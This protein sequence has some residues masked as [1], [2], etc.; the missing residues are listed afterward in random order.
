MV[1]ARLIVL[2]LTLLMPAQLRAESFVDIIARV[3]PGIVGI[4]SHNPLARPPNDL[5][6]TGL[7]VGDGNHVVTAYHVVEGVAKL[8]RGQLSVFIGQGERAAVRGATLVAHDEL[9]DMA[10][11]KVDGKPL[12]PLKLHRGDRVPDGTGIAFTG[13]PVGAVYGL[14]PATHR[15]IVAASTPMARPLVTAGE[16]TPEMIHRLQE[17]IVVYQLDATA[18]PGNSGGPVYSDT[19][20]EVIAILNSTFVK[21]SKESVFTRPSGVSFAIPISHALRL[22]RRVGLDNAPAP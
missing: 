21:R 7:V 8:A 5:N 13:F 15:G 20:G 9:Y 22:M 10:L 3:K 6:G 2:S 19:T 18:F 1:L 16:L 11:L 4:G 12:V 17:R 14:Y